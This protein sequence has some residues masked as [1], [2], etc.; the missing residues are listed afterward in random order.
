MKVDSIVRLVERSEIEQFVLGLWQTEMFR[1]SQLE[2]GFVHDVVS[3]FAAM[4]VF[5][6]EASNEHDEKSHFSTW[7][8]GMQRRQYDNPYIHD[9][10]SL[11]EMFHAGDMLF[12]G[13]L[14][15][16]AFKRKMQD[17]ELGAS[18]CSEIAAYY[19]FPNLRPLS[20][21]YEIYAD[22]FLADPLMRTRWE[23][24]SSRVTREFMMRRQNIML[25]DQHQDQDD[26]PAFWIKNFTYQN[27]IW[28]NIWIH[29]YDDVETQ[30]E[31][32]RDR[33][34]AG[35]RL[36]ALNDHIDWLLSEDVAK[37][38]DVPFPDEAHAFSGVYWSNKANYD[39]SVARISLQKR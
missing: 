10:Y 2:K 18:V 13:G 23:A 17:N 39:R 28:A 20:F 7:W 31:R 33:V 37:G 5:F 6:Y 11:H 30:M 24:D 34:E 1:N 35:D 3:A 14:S 12:A 8:R 19:A 32:F 26:Q 9:L 4:P 27:E 22:R 36:G 29:R 15:H 21:P 16:D 38:G 25:G